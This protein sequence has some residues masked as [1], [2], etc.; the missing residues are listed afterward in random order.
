[1]FAMTLQLLK[2]TTAEDSCTVS[3]AD[4][5]ENLNLALQVWPSGGTAADAGSRA[6][7]FG[8]GKPRSFGVEAI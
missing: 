1:M 5:P 7:S 8:G 4:H 3:A 6:S 2:C